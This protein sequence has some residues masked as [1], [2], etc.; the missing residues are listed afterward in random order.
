MERRSRCACRRKPYYL[1]VVRGGAGE[2]SE[3]GAGERGDCG[4]GDV[5]GGESQTVAGGGVGEGGRRGLRIADTHQPGEYQGGG[6]ED[7]LLSVG[8]VRKPGETIV[9]AVSQTVIRP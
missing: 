2:R 3:R 5:G 4:G 6:A 9:L 8:P 1:E 7:G